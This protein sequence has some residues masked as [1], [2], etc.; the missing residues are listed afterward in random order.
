MAGSSFPLVWSVVMVT[1]TE[2][3]SCEIVASGYA[4]IIKIVKFA[5][6]GVVYEF[7]GLQF[8]LCFPRSKDMWHW[9]HCPDNDPTFDGVS[10]KIGV[11]LVN[12]E[13]DSYISENE[14]ECVGII[15]DGCDSVTIL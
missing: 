4:T 13:V 15:A 7:N 12:W 2:G 9:W 8:V 3:Q 5:T 1:L 6:N 11:T 14:S 10:Y